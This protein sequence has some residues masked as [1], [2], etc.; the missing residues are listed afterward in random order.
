MNSVSE[1]A[2]AAFTG[3]LLKLALYLSLG[4]GC[5]L[6]F[7]PTLPDMSVFTLSDI[8]LHAGG[9][10]YLTFALMLAYPEA[11][12]LRAAAWMFSY[13]VFIEIVQYFVPERSA[14]LK[15]LLM[16]ATGF[17]LGLLVAR[18]LAGRLR[19]LLFSLVERAWPV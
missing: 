2:S 18:A 6:A 13:G 7:V 17:V 5:Y 9:F 16:D 4:V 12:P 3:R 14:E 1:H 8:I 11:T 10:A 15:D 19:Q